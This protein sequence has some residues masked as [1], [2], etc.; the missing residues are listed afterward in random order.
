MLLNR[1]STA[2]RESER[3][4]ERAAASALHACEIAVFDGLGVASLTSDVSS[5]AQPPAHAHTTMRDT[6][7][8]R[9]RDVG[10]QRERERES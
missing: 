8:E 2:K 10:S 1:K 3:E 4:K 6:E 7:R 5:A 9:E